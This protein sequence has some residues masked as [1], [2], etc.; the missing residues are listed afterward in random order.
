[1]RRDSLLLA[2]F[3]A[4]EGAAGVAFAAAAAHAEGGANLATAAQF[5]M[6]HAGAGLALSGLSEKIARPARWFS[7]AAFAL[8]GGVA[9]F[10][11]ALAAGVYGVKPFPYAAPIGGS[12]TILAWLALA[13]FFATRRSSATGVDGA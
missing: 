1:M 11:G 7:I 6:I 9:L 5:L 10:S 3:A 4:L 13:A 2:T 8:Q 12:T